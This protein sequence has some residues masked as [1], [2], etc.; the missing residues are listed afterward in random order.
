MVRLIR[1]DYITLA[2]ASGFC[3]HSQDYLKL[4]ARQGK[5]RAVKI[6]RNWFTTRDWLTEYIKKSE[7]WKN[8]NAKASP[9]KDR[10]D[11]AFKKWDKGNSLSPEDLL[12]KEQY[13][14]WRW[15]LKRAMNEFAGSFLVV[16]AMLLVLTITG[17]NELRQVKQAI[18]D[19]SL[20]LGAQ[21]E[22][23]LPLLGP[24]G[25]LA[26]RYLDWLKDN[27]LA[28]SEDVST[29]YADLN[30]GVEQG[31][32]RDATSLVS[33][34]SSIAKTLSSFENP[35]ARFFTPRQ[36]QPA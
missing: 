35:L 34:P 20:V 28:F 15:N 2:E 1:E 17:I 5:L 22:A 33:L 18:T 21:M 24:L 16:S 12:L 14:Q 30:T 26:G 27:T 9:T 7:E 36:G 6:G 10:W 31:I 29:L 4:R 25:D 23:T 13:A 19:R 3:L 11:L 32:S 8:G